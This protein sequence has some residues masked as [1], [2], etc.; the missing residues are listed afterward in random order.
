MRL[1]DFRVCSQ[2]TNN[3][4]FVSL[5]VFDRSTNCKDIFCPYD[6][7]SLAPPFMCN[8]CFLHMMLCK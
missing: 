1:Q 6:D 2:G 4:L 5:Y 3:D 8:D 7:I